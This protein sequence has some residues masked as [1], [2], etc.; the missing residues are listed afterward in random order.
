MVRD[1]NSGNINGGVSFD[2]VM[3]TTVDT[4]EAFSVSSPI[5]NDS[6]T[7]STQVIQWNVAQTD[8]AP[9]SC[10]AVDILLS[11]DSGN[12]FTQTLATNKVNDGSSEV[13]LPS[14]NTE[15]ARIKI[16]CANN[17]F[18]AINKGDFSIVVNDGVLVKI[19]GQQNIQI[20]QDSSITLTPDMFTYE[21]DAASTITVNAG[22][23]YSVSGT[24][25]APNTGFTGTLNVGVVGHLGTANSDVF[26]TTITVEPPEI[27]VSITGQQAISIN[28]GASIVLTPSMFNYEKDTA[29][30]ITVNAGNNYSVSD[31]K[32]TPNASFSG[33]LTVGIIGHKDS[34]SSSEFLA[35][36]TVIVQPTTQPPKPSSSG[37]GSIWLLLLGSAY[38]MRRTTAS[39]I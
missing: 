27:V 12:S 28:Q 21:Q 3:V 38:V 17:I 1:G 7:T 30:T 14:M 29:T 15:T 20:P 23:N 8:L 33:T 4:S 36:I 19:I 37:G 34:I 13:I 25:I 9:I 5:K 6:W 10:A 35:S 26:V 31:N 22:E 24:R 18:F 32:V 16:Q 39:L 11:T 2:E